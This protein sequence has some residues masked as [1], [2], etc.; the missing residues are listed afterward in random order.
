MCT[1]SDVG[2]RVLDPSLD[3]WEYYILTEE[4]FSEIHFAI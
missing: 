3:G 1:R 2:G 4:L